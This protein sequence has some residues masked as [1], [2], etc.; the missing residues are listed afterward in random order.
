[1]PTPTNLRFYDLPVLAGVLPSFGLDDA[2]EMVAK[3]TDWELGARSAEKKRSGISQLMTR[4]ERK[5]RR[6]RN[7]IQMIGHGEPRCFL[8]LQFRQD[9]EMEADR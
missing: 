9:D 8:L 6:T 1:M 4:L 2:K 7:T 3:G 5:R